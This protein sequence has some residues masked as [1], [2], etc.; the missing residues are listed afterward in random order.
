VFLQV[1]G[2]IE[3]G[4]ARSIKACKQLAHN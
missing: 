4:V 1:A 2:D 3:H